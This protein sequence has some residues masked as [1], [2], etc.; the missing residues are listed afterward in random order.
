MKKII[1]LSLVLI[2][3]V[4]LASSGHGEE[5][6]YLVLTGRA[7]DFWP[8][9][10]NFI[11]FASLLYYLL[12]NPIKSFF[13]NRK[14]DIADQLKDI[15]LKLQVAKDAEK[16]AQL[17]LEE[18]INNSDKIIAD[19]ELEAQILVAKITEASENELKHMEKQF[20]EKI[21]LEEKKSVREVI[22]EVL[23]NNIT[24]DDISIDEEKVVDII[25]RKVA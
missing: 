18:S 13:Q 22:D 9:T 7:N 21:S 17:R 1:L 10:V 6:R 23:T 8:R 24:N 12:A 19:A 14:K 25:S 4:L 20:E 15:E 3:A 16:N 5:S 2:P 11:I